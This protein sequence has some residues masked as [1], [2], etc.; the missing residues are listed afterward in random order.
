MLPKP[1]ILGFDTSAAHVAAALLSGDRIVAEH[2][3]ERAKG[4]DAALFGVLE[5]LLA[6]GEIAWGDLDAIAVGVGPGNFTGVRIAVAAAKGLSLSLGIPTIG[7]NGFEQALYDAP[8]GAKAV[9][10]APRGQ[11]Y[12]AGAGDVG[13][14]YAADDVTAALDGATALIGVEYQAPKLHAGQSTAL[15]A[16]TKLNAPLDPV[17][18]HYLKSPD[19]APPRHPAPQ[20]VA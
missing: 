11:A 10:K 15:V 2:F 17:K 13:A 12:V 9:I 7:V 16:A 14:L 8:K 20:I 3:E 6:E 19:A 4:Q 1:L 18:P 5:G